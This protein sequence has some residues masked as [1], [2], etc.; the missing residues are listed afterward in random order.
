[1]SMSSPH[2]IAVRTPTENYDIHVGQDVLVPFGQHLAELLPGRKAFVVSHPTLL[3]LYGP[4]V[5]GALQQAGFTTET[6]AV[7]E[8]ETS[9][10]LQTAADLYTHLATCGA[11]R[12]SVLCAFG[13]GVVGDLTGFAAATYMRGIPFVQIPTTLLAMV[14]SSIGGKTG[15][16]HELGKN[17]IG[18]FYPPRAVCTD[19]ALLRSLPERE[20]LCGLSE[21]VK[22]GV[23]DDTELFT[24]M[25]RE[26]EAIRQRDEAVLTT[27]IERAIAVKVRVVEEDPT[28]QGVRAI[29]NFGHTI[30][31]ALE[32]VTAYEQYS[33]GEAVAIGMALVAKLSEMLGLCEPEARNRLFSL[34][35][36]LGLPVAYADIDTQRLIEVMAHDKKAIDGVVQF[37]LMRDIGSVVYRQQVPTD[38]LESL[39]VEYA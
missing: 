31:H 36:G 39:L 21:I 7:P 37:I 33:H 38:V 26:T 15:V 32:A 20:Y 17:M 24:L 10:N 35:E 5:T 29:L 2:Q 4:T 27:L 23:I 25:E 16:N 19:I 6:Y 14:D 28:E 34:L 30:G 18:S 3:D 1:M 9:K 13:G 22:A 11:D 8:G 12:R